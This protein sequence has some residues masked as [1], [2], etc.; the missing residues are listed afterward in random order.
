MMRKFILI[1]FCFSI[2][3]IANA[4]N[5][6]PT[7]ENIAARRNFQDD[8]YGMF[9]HWGAS[10]VLGAGE[11][12]MNNRGITVKKYTNLLQFFNPQQFNAAEWV[13]TA[14]NAGMKYI[15]FITRHHDGFSNWDTKYS[16]WKITNTSY[17]KDVLKLLSDECKKQGI[18][19]GLYY[20][21]VDWYR[22]DYPYETGRTGKASG[23]TAKSNYD[24]YLQFMKNQ[25]TE[26][27]TNYGEIMS[28]WFDGHWDQTNPEGNADMS[29]R[30]NWRYEEIYK[31]IHKLQPQCLI[32]NNHHL[33]PFAGEDFQ[34]F[35][36]DLPGQNKTGL[37]FQQASESLPLETCETINGSWGYNITDNNY[38]SVNDLVHYIENAAGR[39]TNFLLNVGPM[40]NGR[41][42]QEFVDTLKAIG[43]WMNKYGE[44]IYGT[45]G[46]IIEPQDWGVLTS[47]NKTLYV[48]LLNVSGKQVF[49]LPGLTLKITDA[50]QFSTR[51]KI[52][53][54]QQAEGV[55]IY[56]EGLQPDKYDTV[57][58]L[59]TKSF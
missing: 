44:T 35:E 57:I 8:K 9:I 58:E 26:L 38:K 14:K 31:L 56:T 46:N 18:K 5:Y 49:F 10:S 20:S 23:R 16:D 17:G 1:L 54:K 3:A 51:K 37:S 4:Q 6:L 28:V 32:G 15:V 25:L 52:N 7:R 27:L 13:A 22:D 50:L 40:P 48:H 33:T 12:V 29:S 45:R 24:S 39:N 41:I 43:D 47:K 19:L 30:I 36:K 2:V 59:T 42:Q 34:M 11:W 55:F 53:F 21:L